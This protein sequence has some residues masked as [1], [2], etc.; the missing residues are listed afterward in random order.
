MPETPRQTRLYLIRHCD[1][2]NPAGVLYGHLP[3][4]GLS[5]RGI[6]QAHSLGRRL[7][8]TPAR[9][10]LTSPLLRARQTA[11]IVAS[12]LP[13]AE[14]TVTEELTEARFGH[15]LQ[16]VRPRD[17]PWRR[18]LWFVHMLCPGLLPGDES[19]AEM[20]ARV[21]APLVRLLETAPGA[22]GICVS[23]GDPI[24]AFWVEADGRPPWA[25]H[26]LQCLKGGMLVLDYEAGRLAA[27]AYLPPSEIPDELAGPGEAPP[28]PG[29]RAA[30]SSTASSPATE[31]SQA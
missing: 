5:A 17:V 1:V 11:E 3:G 29:D 15:H 24:Q 13:G 9:R 2:E 25:L 14:I 6:R 30:V 12:H 26:R 28:G 19:V 20:A 21:R 23:H 27:R 10:I 4:Y 22:G 18:P 16:G 8:A 31:A 7:A